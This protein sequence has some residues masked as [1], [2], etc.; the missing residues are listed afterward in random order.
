LNS[1]APTFRDLQRRLAALIPGVPALEGAATAPSLEVSIQNAAEPPRLMSAAL[2][3]DDR[4]QVHPI[5]LDPTPG[6]VAFL[7]GTQNSRVL[8]YV[9]A[10]PVIVGVVG[11]VVRIR[12]HTRLSTWAMA[13]ETRLYAPLRFLDERWMAGLKQLGLELVDLEIGSDESSAHPFAIRDR[14]IHLIQRHRE[15]AEHALARRWCGSP[16]GVLYV[17]GGLSGDDQVAKSADAV[18]IVKS[19]RTL[20]ADAAD[21]PTLLALREGERTS[22][23]RIT[24]PKRAPVASWYLRIR[25]AQGR[26]PM[27]GL[28]RVEASASSVTGNAIAHQA[29]RISSWVLAERVPVSAPDGRWD[30]MVYGIRDCEQFLRATAVA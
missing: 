10:A 7:D 29:E 18:G 12:R 24:S 13:A 20:Y 26:D 22:V 8:Q 3:E 9:G 11:A 5:R 30:T 28:V 15:E 23:C 21:L 6:F 16:Q 17:D 4:F 19:H 2:I 25:D 14:A 1:D 27:W